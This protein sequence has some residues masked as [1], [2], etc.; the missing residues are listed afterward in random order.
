[1]SNTASFWDLKDFT[2]ILGGVPMHDA[3][4]GK[5]ENFVSVEWDSPDYEDVV[6]SDGHVTRY[7]TND[8]RAT[9]TLRTM[10]TSGLNDRLMAILAADRLTPN[11][12]AVGGVLL[13]DGQGRHVISAAQ[14]WLSGPPGGLEFGKEPSDYEWVIRCAD[15]KGAATFH[16]G[17]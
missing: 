10:Q 8:N 1:M 11:G 13:A 14:A 6:G 17:R 7:N 5:A 15:A 3:D 2:F 4:I 9:I 12:A 16:G